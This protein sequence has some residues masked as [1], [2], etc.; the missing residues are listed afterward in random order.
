MNKLFLWH[1][2]LSPYVEK[3]KMMLREKGL[4]FEFAVPDG[5]GTNVSAPLLKAN[6]RSETPALVDGDVTIF[7]STVICEY[8][9]D[10]WPEPPLRAA[11]PS[12]RARA[13]MIEDICDTHY[14]AVNWGLFELN[15]FNRGKAQGLDQALLASARADTTIMHDWLEMQ[16]GSDDWF[17][18]NAF[19]MADIAVAP[20]V[21]GSELH[22][23]NSILI[24]H[25]AS[26]LPVCSTAP[27]LAARLPNH[28]PTCLCSPASSASSTP[29]ASSATTATTAS[30]G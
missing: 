19:G 9:E 27:A 23:I 15:F 8:I 3:V 21:A 1:T 2:P 12:G 18:G 14:E 24:A 5:I 6:P 17:G 10:K 11:T 20:F 13:R 7:D 22:G 25:S 28:A 30:N 4:E 16:L 29:A 26:G